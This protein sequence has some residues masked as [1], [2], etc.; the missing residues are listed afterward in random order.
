MDESQRLRSGITLVELFAQSTEVLVYRL[1]RVTSHLAS[2][3]SLLDGK[4]R[5]PETCAA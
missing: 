2:F 3:L 5:T 4:Q 1:D